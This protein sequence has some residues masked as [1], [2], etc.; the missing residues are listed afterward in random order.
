MG[1]AARTTDMHLCPMQTPDPIPIPHVGGPLLSLPTNVLIGGLPA[2]TVGQP[3]FCVGLPDLVVMGS[4]TVLIN[5]RPAARM[6]DMT[7]HGGSIV[8]GWPT[9]LVGG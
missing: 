5:N 7:E 3:C 2:S 1:P 4:V 9:V 8:S 6:G